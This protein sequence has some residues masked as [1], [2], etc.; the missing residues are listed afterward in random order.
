MTISRQPDGSW[1]WIGGPVPPGS[2]AITLPRLII[3]RRKYAGREH[4][5]RHEQAH[6]R[7]WKRL[8]AVRFLTRYLG[9]Y[10]RHRLRGFG[11]RAAYRRLGLEIEAEWEA[12]Q[13]R[14]SAAGE[15]G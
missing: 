13:S 1:L 8:G 5:M 7:Q 11:H 2:A 6:V 15:A 3:V 10:L 9:D 12:R 14:V 4:L